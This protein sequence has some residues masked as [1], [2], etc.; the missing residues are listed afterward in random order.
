MVEEAGN[1]CTILLSLLLSISINLI[2]G[3]LMS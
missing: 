1:D 3:V 2:V